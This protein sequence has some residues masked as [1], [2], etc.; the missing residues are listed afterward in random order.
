MT[1]K[2]VILPEMF[3]KNKIRFSDAKPM[4]VPGS[5]KPST[6]KRVYINY[7]DEPLFFQTPKMVAP[8]GVN[9]GSKFNDNPGAPEKF[10]MEVSFNNKEGNESMNHLY[11]M[12]EA[13]DNLVIETAFAR[14]D[15][16]FKR[17]FPDMEVLREKFHPSIRH[18]VNPT[19][20]EKLP[21][22]PRFKLQLPVDNGKF[23]CEAFKPVKFTD[24]NGKAKTRNVEID[25]ME[26]KDRLAGATIQAIVQVGSIWITQTGFGITWRASQLRVSE[27]VNTDG[28][29]PITPDQFDKTKLVF[30]DVK[31]MGGPG[32]KPSAGKR[33]YIN[34]GNGERLYLKTPKMNAP[35]GMGSGS[36]FNDAPPGAPEKFSLELSFSNMDGDEAVQQLY[37]AIEAIDNLVLETAFSRSQ[38]WF[39]KN[40][41]DIE[42]L[43]EKFHPSI[44]YSINPT[45]NERSSYPPRIKLQLPTDKDNGKF[46]FPARSG[47]GGEM[48]DLMDM[49]DRLGGASVQAIVQVGSVWITQSGFG[50]TWRACQLEVTQKA[51]IKGYNFIPTDDDIN[52][53]DDDDAP[54]IKNNTNNKS[55]S[56]SKLT[57]DQRAAMLVDSDED[58]EG[59]NIAS[60]SPIKPSKGGVA[61][62]TASTASKS[63]RM[64]VDSDDDV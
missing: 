36:K 43:K 39:K 49:K 16:W 50:V 18:S 62:A 51:H 57:S 44:R 55:T 12:I 15:A 40:F 13:I 37:N 25:L 33:V 32:G 28:L 7:G 31:A 9:S 30:S 3:D 59:D 41:S 27:R 11:S 26:L 4:G 19:T 22:P 46:N 1:A 53:E 56:S 8:F 14:S 20:N 24:E 38:A 63:T 52:C 2:S 5:N 10:T 29:N 45:T 42:V 17:R 21:Y 58:D 48:I 34:Y 54:I 60:P 35:F 47:D 23:K 6:G 64:L 61:A